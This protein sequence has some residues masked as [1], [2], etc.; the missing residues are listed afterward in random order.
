MLVE[1]ARLSVRNWLGIE[2]DVGPLQEAVTAGLA[3]RQ[4]GL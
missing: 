4:G 2:P 3:G 1:Q